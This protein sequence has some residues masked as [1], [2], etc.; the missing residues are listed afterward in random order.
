MKQEEFIK[1]EQLELLLKK[2]LLFTIG[3]ISFRVTR[4][5]TVWN[6]TTG[7]DLK[8]TA[9]PPNGAPTAESLNPFES[10]SEISFERE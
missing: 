10:T 7:L 2:H 8:T 4:V 3:S 6:E 5:T 1:R 9:D